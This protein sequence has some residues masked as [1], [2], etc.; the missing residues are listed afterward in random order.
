MPA[1]ALPPAG[2][3]LDL[4]EQT[5]PAAS[6]LDMERTLLTSSSPSGAT[7]ARAPGSGS[8]G[9]HRPPPPSH[10]RTAP[11]TAP[12]PGSPASADGSGRSQRRPC[13]RRSR[14]HPGPLGRAIQD[15]DQW[16]PA[17][18]P[19]PSRS[20]GLPRPSATSRLLTHSGT[21]LRPS[22]AVSTLGLGR[23]AGLSEP[24]P[25]TAAA[26]R[27]PLTSSGRRARLDG[28]SRPGRGR[29]AVAA[30][31]LRGRAVTGSA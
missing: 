28:E 21:I 8:G 4:I 15:L 7:A 12:A 11:P 29:F 20:S 26:D 25:A 3:R 30:T 10:R 18:V 2:A 1:M 6:G 27:R 19:R 5:L 13:P 23:G 22:D 16:H 14:R 9:G 24:S 17:M 31:P